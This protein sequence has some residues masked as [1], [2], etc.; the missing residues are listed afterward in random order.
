M[1]HLVAEW[2]TLKNAA[3]DLDDEADNTV[4]AIAKQGNL[5]VLGMVTNYRNGWQAG[6][7][8]K[9]LNSRDARE[10]LIDNILGNLEEHGLAGVNIDLELVKKGDRDKLVDF[11]REL[12]LKLNPEGYLI[13][14]SIPVDDPA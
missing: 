13:T 10:N 9:L 1:T 4:L 7:V 12:R 8:H 2:F 3:G 6:D 5:P 14:Q 11:M